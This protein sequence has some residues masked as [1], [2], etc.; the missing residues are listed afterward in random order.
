MQS[1][2]RVGKHTR[3]EK[4]LRNTNPIANDLIAKNVGIHL[5]DLIVEYMRIWVAVLQHQSQSSGGRGVLEGV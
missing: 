5:G 3:I 2:K 4:V 1:G